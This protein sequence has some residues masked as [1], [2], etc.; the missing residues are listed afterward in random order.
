M[1]SCALTP[2][3]QPL[4]QA[5]VGDAAGLAEVGATIPAPARPAGRRPQLELG[6]H[7]R[8]RR[9]GDDDEVDIG[10]QRGLA[11]RRPLL[12]GEVV[13]AEEA[14]QPPEAAPLHVVERGLAVAGGEEDGGLLRLHQLDDGAGE[15][16]LALEAL[17]LRRPALLH[18]RVV[19]IGE[20]GGLYHPL[21]GPLSN[22]P[23][24]APPGT[25]APAAA[26]RRVAQR[27]TTLTWI[28]GDAAA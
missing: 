14:L 28:L 7:E 15:L 21:V 18:R 2:Q 17:H 11:Q 1:S 16:L 5:G 8:L 27:S 10:G 3:R 12:D 20:V 9:A 22:P 24:R 19:V 25:S 6:T 23:R 26:P 4:A 13:G